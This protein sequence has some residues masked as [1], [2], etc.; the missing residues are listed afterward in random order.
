VKKNIFAV[1]A[2]SSLLGFGSAEASYLTVNDATKNTTLIKALSLNSYFDKS[3]DANIEKILPKGKFANISETFFHA[4]V[5]AT[6]GTFGS[7]DWYSFNTSQANVEAY[8]DIDFTSNLNS[9]IKLYNSAGVQIATNNN[10]KAIDTGTTAPVGF[11][12]STDS[13]LSRVL[14]APGLY[15]LSVGQA[16]SGAQ[17]TLT[18]G[19][20]YTLHVSMASAPAMTTA[21]P[22]PATV[23]LFGSSFAGLLG[24]S[25]MKKKTVA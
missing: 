17:S 9:W 18:P 20:S 25:Q 24:F 11:T 15:Y 14:A 19:Q 6:N 7:R 10:R 12:T 4:S 22:I 23:W 2:F 1:M 8:F 13:Y 5:E 3:F 21:V 16:L